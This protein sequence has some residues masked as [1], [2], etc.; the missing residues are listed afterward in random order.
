MDNCTICENLHNTLEIL[1]N[2]LNKDVGTEIIKYIDDHHKLETVYKEDINY[3]E[4]CIAISVKNKGLPNKIHI[5]FS[6]GCRRRSYEFDIVIK[7]FKDNEE[8]FELDK[9]HCDY[10]WYNSYDFNNYIND[11]IDNNDL[12]VSVETNGHEIFDEEGRI[13]F[14]NLD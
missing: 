6:M 14:P 2:L 8:I 3:I 9:H 5:D 10:E 7:L 11:M 12:E 4:H 13:C 1:T